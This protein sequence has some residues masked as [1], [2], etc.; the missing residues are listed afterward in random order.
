MAPGAQSADNIA[1]YGSAKQ[2]IGDLIHGLDC[3]SNKV[4]E[5]CRDRCFFLV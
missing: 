2:A 1:V 5:F 3:K 4:L